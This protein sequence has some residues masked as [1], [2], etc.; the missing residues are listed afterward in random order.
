MTAD[1][2]SPPTGAQILAV[3]L[4]TN[5]ADAETVRDYLVALVR[6]V[7]RY[8]ECFD[9]KR[10]FGNSGWQSEVYDGLTAAGLDD[11]D[12]TVMRAIEALGEPQAEAEKRA[13]DRI[14]AW[15]RSKDCRH[16]VAAIERGEHL[17]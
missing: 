11:S 1:S 9:G 7:W 8:E 13:E 16:I 6:E 12:A 2:T 3:P 14:V 15:L 5:D 10:P 17:V 4:P